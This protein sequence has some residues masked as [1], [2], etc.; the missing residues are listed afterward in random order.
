MARELGNGGVGPAPHGAQA[1]AVGCCQVGIRRDLMEAGVEDLACAFDG[2]LAHVLGAAQVNRH[3][4][5]SGGE[6]DGLE[7]EPRLETGCGPYQ[8]SMR[9]RY[10]A[11]LARFRIRARD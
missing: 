4:S 6:V 5:G 1:G 2:R 11:E 8:S 7:V 3:V 10:D 9:A